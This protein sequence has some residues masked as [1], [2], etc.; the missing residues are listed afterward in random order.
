[1]REGVP[2]KDLTHSERAAVVSLDDAEHL[3]MQRLEV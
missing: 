1:M 2:A 3:I